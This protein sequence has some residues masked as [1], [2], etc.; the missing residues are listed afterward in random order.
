MTTR[1]QNLRQ[2]SEV[3]TGKNPDLSATL[4]VVS[5]LSGTHN[6]VTERLVILA[7]LSWRWPALAEKDSVLFLRYELFVISLIT[8]DCH[9]EKNR[10]PQTQRCWF[11]RMLEGKR[12]QS[13]G[14]VMGPAFSSN[15]LWNSLN[16]KVPPAWLQSMAHLFGS[17]LLN[18]VGLHPHLIF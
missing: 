6:S 8:W 5:K 2:N 14:W 16:K 12:S 9:G 17:M 7:L 13:Q 11:S 3:V 4:T 18:S 1:C 15:H 10:I